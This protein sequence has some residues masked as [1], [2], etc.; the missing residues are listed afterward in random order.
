VW[1]FVIYLYFWV[2]NQLWQLLSA[3]SASF[4][5]SI[6]IRQFIQ[7]QK[8]VVKQS[9][10]MS[11]KNLEGSFTVQSDSCRYTDDAILADYWWV[12]WFWMSIV[13][14]TCGFDS[15]ANDCW[16][17]YP[18]FYSY[19]LSK[20]ISTVIVALICSCCFIRLSL[21]KS[22][23]HAIWNHMISHSY[24]QM[25]L[26]WQLRHHHCRGQCRQTAAN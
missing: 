21:N 23:L 24:F 3:S 18:C 22:S 5:F 12:V 17:W 19:C 13:L 9:E 6:T 11:C 7:H 1:I 15:V 16:F 10:T 2:Q 20:T 14:A 8:H 25:H 26:L 4:F